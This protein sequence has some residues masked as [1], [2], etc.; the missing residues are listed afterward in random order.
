MIDASMYP[1][2]LKCVLFF[3]VKSF[4]CLVARRSSSRGKIH[5]KNGAKILDR[6]AKI[7][8]ETMFFAIYSSLVH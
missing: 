4:H 2:L 8:S 5:K 6:G 3:N 7:G 1:K